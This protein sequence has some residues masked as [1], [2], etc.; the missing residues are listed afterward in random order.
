MNL[1]AL[2]HYGGSADL[3]IL[4]KYLD[5]FI[6]EKAEQEKKIS[7]LFLQAFSFISD[8]SNWLAITVLA[9]YVLAG[10]MNSIEGKEVMPYLIHSLVR[11]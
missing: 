4:N 5:Y 11:S 3:E 9:Y 2:H 10:R 8:R 7:E 6:V 1:N